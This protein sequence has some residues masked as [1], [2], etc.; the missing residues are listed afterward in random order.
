MSATPK[1][2]GGMEVQPSISEVTTIEYNRW[3]VESEAKAKA[4][5]RKANHDDERTLRKELIEKY[6][7]VGSDH[8][9]EYKEQMTTAKAEVENFRSENLR[10]G[11]EVKEEVDELRRARKA[12]K[13]SW[14]EHGSQLSR[15]FGSE[16]KRR[17]KTQVG[18]MSTRKREASATVRNDIAELERMRT[19]RQQKELAD[20]RTLK[21]AIDSATSDEVTKQAKQQFYDQRKAVGDTTRDNMRQWKES[22]GSEKAEYATKAAAAKN[23]ALLAKK[24]AKEAMEGVREARAKAAKEMRDK[25]NNMDVN[26]KKVKSDLSTTK[27]QVHDMTRTRKFISSDAAAVMSERR[28][29]GSGR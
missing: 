9:S 23:E 20:A 16:Q 14:L 22:R 6:R 1:W 27:K 26:S 5:D 12:Q 3:L 2:K 8:V 19:D 11:I 18:E 10:R 24:A 7:T 21:E 4:D 13:D 28:K 25:R 17:I 29:P 15:E